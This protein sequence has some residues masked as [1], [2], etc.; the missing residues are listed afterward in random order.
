MV[1]VF[2]RL[3]QYD[4][5]VELRVLTMCK[6]FAR[7]TRAGLW[8][9]LDRIEATKEAAVCAVLLDLD[10]RGRLP[11]RLSAVK[12]RVLRAKSLRA[13]AGTLQ[14]IL[15]HAAPKLEAALLS[16]M[17][18]TVPEEE[19]VDVLS[20]EEART[21]EEAAEG[22]A[23]PGSEAS[24]SPTPS[25]HTSAGAS[26]PA[27]AA[28]VAAVTRNGAASA[29]QASARPQPAVSSG[30]APVPWVP[31]ALAAEW[32]LPAALALSLAL[33]LPTARAGGAA[34]QWDAA[35]RRA[36]PP[37]P[38]AKL[39]ACQRS[40]GRTSL[41]ALGPALQ[42][43]RGAVA[44]HAQRGGIPGSGG[45]VAAA[46]LSALGA[47]EEALEGEAGPGTLLTAV[48]AFRACLHWRQQAEPAAGGGGAASLL[49]RWRLAGSGPFLLGAL[50]PAPARDA[51]SVAGNASL[52][53]VAAGGEGA[54]RT[55]HTQGSPSSALAAA[56]HAV[57]EAAPR[58]TVALLVDA[59]G[60]QALLESYAAVAAED[61]LATGSRCG[62]ADAA[63][64]AAAIVTDAG[65]Y[66]V[67]FV[68]AKSAD[69]AALVAAPLTAG[70]PCARVCTMCPA[71]APD[72]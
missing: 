15:D 19:D 11:R 17:R 8:E 60:P 57:C 32:P 1:R 69:A 30:D 28:T 72:V 42:T 24:H 31:E 59:S 13:E 20:D 4:P 44:Q 26:P 21:A 40:L 58:T 37:V 55:V 38:H 48:P 49:L 9:A 7:S 50:P 5:V 33:A 65:P 18:Q 62:G 61:G 14:F 46:A 12:K 25:P 41:A 54:R 66:C 3:R 39:K 2:F 63:Y 29:P 51:E 34:A 47:V 64:A 71:D 70:N 67:V 27:A 23:P 52:R 6:A 53:A 36:A 43:L 35:L 16:K 68:A 22:P 56:A 45:A 10:R